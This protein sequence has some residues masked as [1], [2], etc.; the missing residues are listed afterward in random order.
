MSSQVRKMALGGLTV[1]EAMRMQVVGFPGSASIDAGVRSLIKY[2]IN[3]LLIT[4]SNES[5]V[6]VVS[7]TDVM[8]AYY[9]ELPIESPLEQIMIS[10]PLFCGPDDTLESA[11]HVMR[12]RSV[13][14]L[15]VSG[16]SSGKPI[17]ILAYPDIV[18]LLYS[19]CR[20]C[21]QSIV[22][23]RAL[24]LVED[25]S[26]RFKVKEVMTP[27]VTSFSEN[28]SLLEIMEGLS[29]NRF[30][31]VLITDGEGTPSGVISKTDL[32]LAYKHG[33]SSEVPAR[34][35]VARA[36]VRSCDEDDFIEDA[37]RT[38]IFS[39]V[40]RLFVHSGDPRNIIG[41][42]SL[43]DAARVRSGSCH[44]CVGSRI[45]IEGSAGS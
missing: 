23:R 35:I 32:I 18:G 4:D 10:P 14:R 43:S 21:E 7:K 9:A 39:E 3:A 41:V 5:A 12:S 22:N 16:D 33:V 31:A 24:N 15:Y 2:K 45:R 34:S 29:V 36:P 11:L 20:S 25:S 27:S 38:M 19:Y 40:Q 30:G 44:A 8:G 17:G 6:G 28:D 37:I 26:L 1:R 13:Y 42:F